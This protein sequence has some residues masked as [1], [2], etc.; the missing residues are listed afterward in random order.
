MQIFIPLLLLVFTSL[1]ASAEIFT[2]K[3]ENGVTHFS[4]EKPYEQ[5]A[6]SIVVEE[7]MPVSLTPPPS[8][9]VEKEVTEN[10]PEAEINTATEVEKTVSE[11]QNVNSHNINNPAHD[12]APEQAQQSP[13]DVKK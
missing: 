11:M 8:S 4:E 10:A 2:W 6:E 5:E 9:E 12:A 1:S 13:K 3:D 7:K